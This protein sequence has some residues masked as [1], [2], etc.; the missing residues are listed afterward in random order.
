MSF[1]SRCL[2]AAAIAA[3]VIL[4]GCAAPGVHAPERRPEDVRAEIVRLLPNGAKDREVL[5]S[6]L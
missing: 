2:A 3:L 4:A 5:I 1:V 6:P